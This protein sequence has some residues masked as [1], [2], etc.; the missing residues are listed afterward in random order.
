MTLEVEDI[1]EG[2]VDTA[3]GRGQYVLS[4]NLNSGE[5]YLNALRALR[6]G[7]R[8]TVSVDANSS[9][10][11]GVTNLIGALYQLVENGRVCSGL[12]A[13]NAPRTAVGLRRDGSLVMYTIDGRQ[14]GYS[15]GATLTQVAERMVELGCETALSLDGGGSTRWSRRIPTARR[16]RL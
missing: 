2:S 3:V 1:V 13:G 5:N 16:H 12:S 11:D 9:E 7:D 10:W 6:V 14:S 15:V 4:A 8:I